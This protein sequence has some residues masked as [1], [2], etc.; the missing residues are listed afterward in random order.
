HMLERMLVHSGGIEASLK[1]MT[2]GREIAAGLL[3]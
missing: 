2:Q 3:G 1:E